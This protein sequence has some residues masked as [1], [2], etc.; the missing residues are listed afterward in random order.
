[1]SVS[2][3]HADLD[4][5]VLPGVADLTAAGVAI[6]RTI[7]ARQ[8]AL[9]SGWGGSNVCRSVYLNT[10]T[11]SSDTFTIRIP[12]G[13]T[14]CDIQVLAYG[15]GTVTITSTVD[16]TGTKWT[17]ASPHDGSSD[18]EM[19]RWHGTGGPLPSSLGATSGR[20]VTVAS[21]ASWSWDNVDLTIALAAETRVGILAI[22][23]RPI[24][25]PR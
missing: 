4:I 20:A 1:M 23:I 18:L 8:H 17:I 7:A 24:H 5:I 2:P 6:L 25:Q 11:S 12:P 3:N 22:E 9:M 13:V 19:A 10:T 21:S 15:T 14:E 16:A